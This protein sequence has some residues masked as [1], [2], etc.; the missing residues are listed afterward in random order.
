MIEKFREY[1]LVTVGFTLVAFS[2]E[3]F[4]APNKIAAGGVSGLA[5]II[6]N[7]FPKATIGL[8]MLMMN[9][10]LFIVAFL[11]I[12]KKFGG[13][14]IYAS[15]GLSGVIWVMDH[16]SIEKLV[17]THD[18]FLATIFGTI[19]SAIGMAI[20]FNENA[21]T[22][23]TDI[24]AKI[25]NKFFHI[26]IGKGL[27]SVDFI[28]TIFAG[29]SFGANVGMYAL[30]SV[31]MNGFVIDTVIEG[32]NMAKAVMVIST[33]TDAISTYIIEQLDRGCT[34]FEGKGAYSKRKTDILYTV[35]GRREFIKLRKFIKEVDQKSFITVSNAH[36][37]LGEGFQ[38]IVEDE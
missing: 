10:I 29:A 6:N 23:G 31:I 11:V 36:E 21:S 27:L 30:L 14:S 37:V 20:V 5:I 3:L 8:L 18:L 9:V 16:L 25:L 12:G 7:F 35:L 34:I 17:L 19:L 1:L 38:D 26:D 28:I 32:L 4:L 33:K 24:I 2:I 22:G 13:K 15:L